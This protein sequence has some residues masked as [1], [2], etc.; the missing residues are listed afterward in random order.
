MRRWE[1]LLALGAVIAASAGALPLAGRWY[2]T[3]AA[4]LALAIVGAARLAAAL[5]G[6]KPPISDAAERARRIREQR[7]RR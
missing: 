6:R 7:H 1:T 3:L 4:L 5:S 2:F